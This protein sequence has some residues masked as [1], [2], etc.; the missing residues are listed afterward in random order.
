MGSGV[1]RVGIILHDV[2]GADFLTSALR[3]RLGNFLDLRAG[4]E[5]RN[6][7]HVV[8]ESLE[9]RVNICNLLRRQ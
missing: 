8:T 4:D 3:N 5:K 7:Q 1:D 2:S 6:V 9:L